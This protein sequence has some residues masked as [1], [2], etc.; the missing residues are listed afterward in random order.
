[1]TERYVGA[2]LTASCAVILEAKL[3]MLYWDY[4][5]Q[6]VAWCKNVVLHNKTNRTLFE[7]VMEMIALTFIM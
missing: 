2:I 7:V 1:M 5:V 6:H 3:L 4:T